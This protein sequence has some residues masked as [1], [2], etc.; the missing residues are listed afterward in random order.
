[1]IFAGVDFREQQYIQPAI[2]PARG[3]DN[4][5]NKEGLCRLIHRGI[6]QSNAMV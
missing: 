5:R 6:N 4:T 1:M 3:W 2:H